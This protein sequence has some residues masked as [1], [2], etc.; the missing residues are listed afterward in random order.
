[1][2]VEPAGPEAFRVAGELHASSAGRL[3]EIDAGAGIDGPVSL[4]LYDLTFLDTSGLRGLF[5]LAQR[6]DHEVVLKNPRST[7][8]RARD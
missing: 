8:R 3:E 7:I 6:L 4:D 5:R 2:E 1:M